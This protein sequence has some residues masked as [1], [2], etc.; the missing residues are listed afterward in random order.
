MATSTVTTNKNRATVLALVTALAVPF[1]G[2][3]QYAYYDPPGILTVC[4]GSTTDVA[5]N[6]KYSL[7]ECKVRLDK[8]MLN[9]IIIVENCTK[10][11]NLSVN[12]TVAFADMVYNI[13]PKAVCDTTNSTLARKLKAGNIVGACEQIPRWNKAIVAG[14]M[15]PLPGLT[16]RRNVEAELCK[17]PDQIGSENV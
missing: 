3:R 15:I 10:D 16:K 14:Q 7:D 1:E 9:A 6:R 8:D 2:L 13:G 17:K 12:Q 11:L 4:Y 5:R